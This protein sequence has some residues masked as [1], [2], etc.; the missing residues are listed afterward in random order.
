M[1]CWPLT[2]SNQLEPYT[3]IYIFDSNMMQSAVRSLESVLISSRPNWHQLRFIFITEHDEVHRLELAISCIH[4]N[5]GD[6]ATYNIPFSYSIYGIHDVG[7][8]VVTSKEE[9]QHFH[10][11]VH[12]PEKSYLQ[13]DFNFIRLYL[14]NVIQNVSNLDIHYVNEKHMD[15]LEYANHLPL[16]A[17]LYLDVDTICTQ[18]IISL[19]EC[20]ECLPIG[21]NGLVLAMA[22]KKMKFSSYEIDLSQKIIQEWNL[23]HN[24]SYTIHSERMAYNAGVLLVNLNQWEY[25]NLTQHYQYWM[26]ENSRSK[27]FSLG[28]NPIML[29]GTGTHQITTFPST[30]NTEVT[31][32]TFHRFRKMKSKA[33]YHF[34]SSPKPWQL[35]ASS[36]YRKWFENDILNGM[37]QRQGEKYVM[38]KHCW[39]YL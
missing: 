18:N 7:R 2:N 27:L 26:N 21:G 15:H 33:I 13:S 4:N 16:H 34:K 24:E 25:A 14:P 28:T 12:D 23:S 38:Q 20:K 8:D 5:Y 11:K 19:F 35:G 36:S 22:Q 39:S 29:M 37:M 30:W 1:L 31:R 32:L 10:T 3:I 9:G 6:S 17:S